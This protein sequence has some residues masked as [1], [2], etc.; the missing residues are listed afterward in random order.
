[1]IEDPNPQRTPLSDLGEFGLIERL[2][3][4]IVHV[5]P[6]TLVG[7]GDDAAVLRPEKDQDLLLST[8][9]L[10]EGVHFD[11][12]YV[13]MKHLGYK[14]AVVNF[15]DIY[16]MGGR[17]TQ[18]TVSM[19]VSN[20]FPVEALDEIF[21]GLRQACL[22]YGVD[23]VGGDTTSNPSG[24]ALSL[25]VLGHVNK[26][27][28]VMRSGAKATDLIVVSGDLGG[29]YMGL[30]VLER[31]KA[32]YLANPNLQPDLSDYQYP[33]E[34]QLKPEARKDIIALLGELGVKPTSMM[35]ISDGLSS[36]L[37]HLTKASG[38]GCVVFEDK[39]PV[40]PV[41][42]RTCE[43]FGIHP[44]TAMM[45]GGEDYEL[46]FTVAL[47]DYDKIKGNPS[48]TPVGHMTAS[49]GAYLVNKSGAH[50]ELSAQGWKAF[51]A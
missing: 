7:V 50:V 2:T 10:I 39:L 12:S 13:P 36:E 40:D 44:V 42:L 5:Q 30:Q 49:S 19:A 26:G 14:A 34:R 43:E 9:M 25:T 22:A 17:P 23:L 33:I 6:S 11:L 47:E 45:N 37:R 31:E 3:A 46:V 38:L 51:S 21:G 1:M 27:E 35:D 20:R 48:I 24:L 16:A 4:D 18:L 41:V 28:A 32:T 15:S 29:A 8:D